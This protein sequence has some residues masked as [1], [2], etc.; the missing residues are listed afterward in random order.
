VI[1]L[2]LLDVEALVLNLPPPTAELR[3][4]KDYL[5][6]AQTLMAGSKTCHIAEARG[7]HF[8]AVLPLS[9]QRAHPAVLIQIIF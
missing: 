6:V 4:L 2:V 5:I 9:Y 3:H 1:A 8:R 7:R